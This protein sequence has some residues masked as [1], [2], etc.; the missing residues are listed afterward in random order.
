MLLMC[1]C[2]CVCVC[3]CITSRVRFWYILVNSLHWNTHVPLIC[4]NQ[5]MQ[6]D[7]GPTD[8]I[9]CFKCSFCDFCKFEKPLLQWTSTLCICIIDFLFYEFIE[10]SAV[11]LI[12]CDRLYFR[13]KLHLMV[14]QLCNVS[15]IILTTNK[16]VQNIRNKKFPL[17]EYCYSV[18]Y[19]HI[20]VNW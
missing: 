13:W 2:V 9:W 18:L 20:R 7:P 11:Y 15:F 3:V 12:H 16:I 1:V 14:L 8:E 6:K 10:L 4:M 5:V 17:H 19:L